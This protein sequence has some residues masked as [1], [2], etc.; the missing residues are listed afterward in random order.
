MSAGP[1]RGATEPNTAWRA[2]PALALG[3]RFVAF[4]TP[5][6]AAYLAI[7]LVGSRLY[8]PDGWWG[9]AL[10]ILQAG[11]VGAVVSNA[12]GRVTRRLLP[13][14]TLLRLTLIFPDQAPSRF[15]VALRSGTVRQMRQRARELEQHGLGATAAE[16]AENAIVLVNGLGRHDRL[17]RGHTERVRA[18]ADLIADEM[19][20]SESDRNWLAWGVLL[21][22][23]GKMTVPPE[24]LNKA[25]KLTD[26]EW[27]V[28]KNHPAAGAE[29]LRPLEPWLGDWV[30]AAGEHHERWDGR[31][32]PDGLHEHEI[33]LA[34]RITAVADAYDVITS[35]RS[36]K[37]P[38]S[39]EAA[40]Q[41]LVDCSGT[42][43]DPVVVRAM[44]AASIG[45]RPAIGS[46][47]WLTEIPV[48][49]GAVAVGATPVAGVVGTAA[50]TTAALLGLG[51][52]S[53]ARRA[54]F[55][56]ELQAFSNGQIAAVEMVA[57]PDA[58]GATASTAP[59]DVR[60]PTST[61]PAAD[62]SVPP[63][64]TSTAPTTGPTADPTEVAPTD[65]PVVGPSGTTV[66][67]VTVPPVTVPP[68][69]V[70]ATT[71]PSGPIPTTTVPATTV[72]SVTVPSVTVPSV[73]V[74]SV[75][76]PSVTVPSVTV[77]PSVS[78]PELTVPSISTPLVT[79][80]P[81]AVP[82]IT[83]PPITTPSITTPPV[84]T[85][86]LTVP[87]LTTPEITLPL[88]PLGGLFG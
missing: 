1:T 67:P 12:V 43:F 4:A 30:R 38:M 48:V 41:E 16:A 78:T 49:R 60:V 83:T 58:G 42:Q 34:G 62:P 14:A 76:V 46:L 17:T 75:T 81:I 2:S 70:P 27:Q 47:A 22:D 45:R 80:P 35:K 56:S 73:T 86:L 40:R 51:D 71:V 11:V 72:P 9:L 6:L 63:P 77:V 18:Y 79:T 54:A 8:R 50:F 69:V 23:V 15:G 55:A 29:M 10:W 74:P 25:E 85:P 20:L 21:H 7:R 28:L 52:D 66:P 31:G 33:S 59:A 87:D 84:S 88:P 53:S 64:T 39:A 82:S 13:L 37:E 68:V 36:Y 32:Y 61:I 44:L 57:E 3:V 24:V 65:P 26:D 5:V 19:G